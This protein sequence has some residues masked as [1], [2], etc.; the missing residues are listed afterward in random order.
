MS[1][2]MWS[3]LAF[4]MGFVYLQCKTNIKMHSHIQFLHER[5]TKL[6][7]KSGKDL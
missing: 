6:E 2:Y 3:F 7:E 4:V 5:I 1:S